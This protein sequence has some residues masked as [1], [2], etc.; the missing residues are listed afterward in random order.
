[1]SNQKKL[2]SGGKWS[3]FKL[4]AVQ[5]INIGTIAVL[6]RQLDPVH[7]GIVALANVALRFFNVIAAQGVNQYI[8]FDNSEQFEDKRNAAFWLNLVFAFVAVALGF[9]SIPFVADFYDEPQ[10]RWV[11]AV[12]FLR[13]PFDLTAKLADGVMQ[14]ELVFKAIEIRDTVIQLAVGISSIVMALMGFGVWSLVIPGALSSPIKV[15]VSFQLITWRPALKLHLQYWKEIW[16]YSSNIIG[17]SFV[18]FLISQGDTLLVGKLLG[19]LSLGIYNLSWNASNILSKTLVTTTNKLA[20]PA[21]SKSKG[22]VDRMY[23]GYSKVLTTISAITFPALMWMMVSAKYVILTLYGP[24]WMEAVVPL[25]IL[26]IYAI[27]YSVGAPTGSVYKSLGRPDLSLKLGL[28]V[29][30]FYVIGIWWGSYYGIVGVAAGVTVARTVFGLIG[31][32][33]AGDLLGRSLWEVL[34]PMRDSFFA[35]VGSALITWGVSVGINHYLFEMH[36][37]LGLIIN[38]MVMAGSYFLFAKFLFPKLGSW[39]FQILDDAVLNHLRK[40]KK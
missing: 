18:N 24:K 15:L 27:R 35:A 29:L 16:K 8:V 22:D 21:F 23:Q 32:K 36:H 13:F 33:I 37:V 1:M 31:F 25:Q 4:L 7:F 9:I 20:L 5:L 30:P 28:G 39:I 3:L 19:S 14:K 17:S 11:L 34:A 10:L 2:L 6:S 12:L 38:L 40:K 26:L